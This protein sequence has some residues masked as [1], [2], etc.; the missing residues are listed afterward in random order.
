MDQICDVCGRSLPKTTQYFKKYSHKTDGRNFHTTCKECEKKKEIE[1]EWKDGKL[2]CHVCG[3][4]LDPSE[5]HST[6]INGAKYYVRGGKDKRCRE[7]KNKQNKEAR[8][9]YNS[10]KALHRILQD[11]WFDAKYRAEQ[12]GIPFTITKE[13][14]QYLWNQQKGLCAIS[15]IPMT[16]TLDQGRVYT[17]I[18]IDQIEPSKGYTIDNIQLVCMGVN[19]IKSD[20]DMETVL[21]LCKSI[22][23]NYNSANARKWNKG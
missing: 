13:D 10:D 11:R 3:R 22:L 6:G 17:N 12:K 5:F 19:Q 9:H 1:T 23:D 15:K 21:F 16:Y 7:C 2:L 14:L 4:Y 8:S 18:S 20:L